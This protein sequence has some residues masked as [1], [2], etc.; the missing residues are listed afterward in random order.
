MNN[1]THNQAVQEFMRLCK[2]N[3]REKY[4]EVCKKYPTLSPQ[5][6]KQVHEHEFPYSASERDALYGTDE[7]FENH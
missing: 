1:K 6:W 3:D 5:Q 2:Q 7:S 4:D